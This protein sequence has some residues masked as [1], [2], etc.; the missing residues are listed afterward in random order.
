MREHWNDGFRTIEINRVRGP[1][2]E[3]LWCTIPVLGGISIFLT[4]EAARM[5]VKGYGY[6]SRGKAPTRRRG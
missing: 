2:E 1:D 4:L 3:T 6:L 5:H